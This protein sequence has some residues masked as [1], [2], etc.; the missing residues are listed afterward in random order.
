MYAHNHT[1]DRQYFAK[2]SGGRLNGVEMFWMDR[3]KCLLRCFEWLLSGPSEKIS[4]KSVILVPRY[5]LGGTKVI[6]IIKTK[7]SEIK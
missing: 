4:P 1:L 3:A 7:T 2:V 6:K 5:G